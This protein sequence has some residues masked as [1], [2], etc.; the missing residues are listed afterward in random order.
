MNINVRYNLDKAY[1]NGTSQKIIKNHLYKRKVS[2]KH[3]IDKTVSVY[4]WVSVMGSNFKVNTNFK[5]SPRQWDFNSKRPKRTYEHY[6]AINTL[7]NR[8]Q[9]EVEGNILNAQIKNPTLTYE[10]IQEIVK[11]TIGGNKPK[12]KANN[13]I[14]VLEEFIQEKYTHVN[15]N[16]KKKYQTFE[17]VMKEYKRESR[18]N[19]TFYN[20]N[21]QFETSFKKYLSEEKGLLNSSIDK[22]LTSFKVFMRWAIDRGYTDNDSFK[23]FKP[24]KYS[25][26]VI[27]LTSKELELIINLD[28]SD[29]QE[30]ENVRDC[31]L[32]QCYTGQRYGDIRNLSPSEIMQRDDGW[33]WHLYQQKGNKPQKVIVPIV[34]DA[35]EILLKYYDSN[36]VRIFPSITNQ[37]ANRYIK[38]VC[39]KAGINS[40]IHQVRYSGLKKIEFNKPKY[41]CISTHAA[42]RTF[43]T[44]SIEKGMNPET[45]MKITGH[46]NYK[47]MNLYKKITD[48][49]VRKECEKAWK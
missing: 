11:N 37:K 10:E 44:L 12:P 16:T 21:S 19:L 46:E 2:T 33:E 35:K 24:V 47:T 29:N 3:L 27:F 49:F 28:L 15:H 1:K 22:Y 6:T 38:E 8:M 23:K 9:S 7:L 4:L 45:I 13:F 36:K 34:N 40:N 20:I 43:I 39:K 17:K 31:F 42:R 41:D 18:Y 48:D 14:S 30:L 25:S 32:F 26:E 5:I